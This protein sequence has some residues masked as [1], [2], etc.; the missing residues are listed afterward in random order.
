MHLPRRSPM[1]RIARA[2]A[3][4]LEERRLLSATLFKDINTGTQGSVPRGLGAAG[5][6]VYFDAEPLVA[7]DSVYQ[8]DG[9]DA[10]TRAIQLP[11]GFADPLAITQIAPNKI[12]AAVGTQLWETSGSVAD[13]T[14]L[15][16]LPS[17]PAYFQAAGGKLFLGVD[18][19]LWVSDGTAAGTL[20][21][22]GA[23]AGLDS[24]AAVGNRIVFCTFDGGVFVSDGTAA[25]TVSLSSPVSNAQVTGAGSK[26]YFFSQSGVWQT[27]GT[28]AGTSP[29]PSVNEQVI[30]FALGTPSGLLFFGGADTKLYET[31]GTSTQFL[32]PIYAGLLNL[33]VFV[34]GR[35]IFGGVSGSNSG[36]WSSDGT[37]AGTSFLTPLDAS[38][39]ETLT[40]AG[41]LALFRY[42]DG[43]HGLEWWKTDGTL[44]GTT[45]FKDINPHG[46]ALL[47]TL[48]FPPPVE[49]LGDEIFFTADDGFH[50]MELWKSDGTAAGTAMVKDI[51]TTPASSVPDVLTDVNGTLYFTATDDH[52][53]Q[54]WTSDGTPAGTHRLDL[55]TREASLAVQRFVQLGDKTVLFTFEQAWVT[56]GTAAGTSRI[57]SLDSAMAGPIYPNLVAESEN[58]IYFFTITSNNT[59]ALWRTDGTEA[60]TQMLKT[61]QGVCS[62]LRPVAGG[63]V[64]FLHNGSDGLSVWASDGTVAG[65]TILG[66]PLEVPSGSPS[67][68]LENVLPDVVFVNGD[69]YVAIVIS[70]IN[71]PPPRF[72]PYQLWR[73]GPSGNAMVFQTSTTPSGRDAGPIS[74]NGTFLIMV[75]G[76]LYRLDPATGA[77]S[78]LTNGN[79]EVR[80]GMTISGGLGY[81]VVNPSS[82]PQLWVTD[83]TAAGTRAIASFDGGAAVTE[84]SS[85]SGMIALV[86]QNQSTDDVWVS[87]GTAQGTRD[88]ASFTGT[89]YINPVTGVPTFFGGQLFFGAWDAAHGI[90][91]WSADISGSIAG[92]VFNDSNHNGAQDP[93]EGGLAGVTV[94]IDT[95][96]NGILDP[97]E[98]SVVTRPDGA[99]T[100]SGLPPGNAVVRQIPP[101]G[102]RLTSPLTDP[103]PLTVHSALTSA[104]PVFGD[105]Q[106]STVPMNFDYLLTLAQHYGQSGTFAT[107]DVTGD[108]QV[109][110]DDLLLLAQ[111]YGHPLSTN[112]AFV[113][114]ADSLPLLKRS[115][116]A[117]KR[118]P[119]R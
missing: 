95:N 89:L 66:T 103:G 34:N 58:L 80:P 42:D 110:F 71:G 100:L 50:G 75:S 15:A 108:G 49:H 35:V 111:N 99:Y 72:L 46:D 87:D 5:N 40:Q 97:G 65:T 96:N 93:G 92:S 101:A 47:P 26:A 82:Q 76:T 9:T 53:T 30:D 57:L 36:L 29:V 70:P 118:S 104:G 4:A 6:L 107:G 13:A 74:L 52:G 19:Q 12:I 116:P 38:D 27:D 51:S 31:D 117:L 17:Q 21:V 59:A 25:G 23:Q 24:I 77:T 22:P 43:V 11:W 114:A 78:P 105:V 20:Q 44:E 81:F 64:E 91:L 113:A 48:G 8:T 14:L 102:W 86:V 115:R 83:G 90:E 3:E 67:T 10:G 56:D 45:L 68:S 94:F 33:G 39:E 112:T 2:C 18:G 88:L 32:G 85:G 54:P 106:V 61:F 55:V 37:Q 60:G 84:I 1:G 28:P 62:A 63:R 109:N 69:Y 79:Q 119:V 98:A 73:I 16:T 41:S 7:Q